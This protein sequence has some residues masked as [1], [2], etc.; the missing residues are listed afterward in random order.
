MKRLALLSCA[1]VASFTLLTQAANAGVVTRGHVNNLQD[2]SHWK[3]EFRTVPPQ[4]V[5][6]A[7][8]AEQ[9]RVSHTLP[10]YTNS[11]KSPLNGQTYNYSIVGTDPTK[12]LDVDDGQVSCRSRCAS[13]SRTA[14]CSTPR[15][16][17]QRHGFRR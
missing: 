15:A 11:I 3:L 17:L 4:N 5:N 10:F 1:A 8:L 7:T 16:R 12:S 6:F 2:R 14:S 13:T 9:A